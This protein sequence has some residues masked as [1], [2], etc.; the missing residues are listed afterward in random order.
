MGKITSMDVGDI[1]N[2]TAM[3]ISS[4]SRNL[5][6]GSGIYT[7]KIKQL[8]GTKIVPL[9]YDNITLNTDIQ[10]H[11]KSLLGKYDLSES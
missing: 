1:Q 7:K 10:D 4:P 6:W 3:N 2:R 9:E 11:I 8:I 5:D